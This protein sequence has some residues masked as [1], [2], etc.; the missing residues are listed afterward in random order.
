[1]AVKILLA[2]YSNKGHLSYTLGSGKSTSYL[3]RRKN[4]AERMTLQDIFLE[5]IDAYLMG[6]DSLEERRA[7]CDMREKIS[8]N[9]S[10]DYLRSLV[11]DFTQPLEGQLAEEV[12]WYRPS[13]I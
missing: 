12:R 5:M 9:P 8:S 2:H 1:L 6:V 13:S 3:I 4:M 11:H 10:E 7:I